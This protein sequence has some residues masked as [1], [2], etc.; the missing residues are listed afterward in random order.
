MEKCINCR[1][2]DDRVGNVCRLLQRDNFLRFSCLQMCGI[3]KCFL[4]KRVKIHNAQTLQM[5]KH[6]PELEKAFLIP[7]PSLD[8]WA[9]DKSGNL[10]L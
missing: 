1:H 8:D 3:S 7:V 4:L 6:T 2:N 9:P 5:L 10:R